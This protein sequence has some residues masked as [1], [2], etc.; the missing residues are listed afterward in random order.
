MSFEVI[1]MEQLENKYPCRADFIRI[2]YSMISNPQE[3]FPQAIY[4]SGHTGTGKTAIVKDFLKTPG[5]KT[6]R[7]VHV[8]CVECYSTKILYEHI[9]EVLLASEARCD[10]F[11][12]FVEIL[13][14]SNVE[15]GN[16]FVIALDNADRLRDM[17][18]NILPSLLRLQEFT[19]LNI[20]VLLISQI[21]LE[22]YHC[23]TGLSEIISLYTPQYTKVE[24]LKILSGNFENNLRMVR[25]RIN[26]TSCEESRQNQ[27]AIVDQITQEFYNNYLNVFLSVFY[28]AC[29]DV[30]ELKITASKCFFTYIEPVLNGTVEIT[31]VARLWRN[32]AA[33]L[34]SSLSQVYMRFDKSEK[35]V[36][37]FA[38]SQN[39]E[40]NSADNSLRKLAQTFELPFYGKYLLIAAFLASHNSAKE[41]KRL[42]VKHHGKQRKRMQSVNAKAKVAEKM[43]SS[44][45][46][47]SF[48]L[49]RLLAIFYAILDEKVGLTCNL[50][51]QISTLVHLKLL[52][53]VSGENNVMDGSARLQCTVGLEFV[54]YI[55]KI[56][57]FNVY[58]YLCDFA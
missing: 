45:G 43:S 14:L 24:T 48:S 37:C 42:F 29:R 54:L 21:P 36:R 40:G 19:G 11:K 57:G 30:P 13:R 38:R 2:L 10:T 1:S 41:D 16:A 33:P 51:S 53:F 18:N 4:I 49:D 27:C 46:P 15:V 55:G 23:K 22:K 7:A 26:S 52:G 58:Q 56:V 3:N 9:L 20:C 39:Y 44:L 28:K 35:E 31:D 32:I 47:K 6:F 34:R 50:L 17:D 5:F 25:S 8:N 12:E